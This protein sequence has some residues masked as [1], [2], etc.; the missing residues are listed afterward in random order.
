MGS[1]LVQSSGSHGLIEPSL[2]SGSGH[3]GLEKD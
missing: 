2:H 3:W 1:I